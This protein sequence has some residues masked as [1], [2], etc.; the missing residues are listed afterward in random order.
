M[1]GFDIEHISKVKDDVRLLEKIATER[2]K[3]YV[4]QGIDWIYILQKLKIN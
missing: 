4:L 2:E 1:I 3:E